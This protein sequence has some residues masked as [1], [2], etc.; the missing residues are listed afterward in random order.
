[1][2]GL[3]K[4]RHPAAERVEVLLQPD[5]RRQPR[6]RSTKLPEHDAERVSR[7]ARSRD[8]WRDFAA[9]PDHHPVRARMTRGAGKRI[10][11]GHRVHLRRRCPARHPAPRPPARS[12]SPRSSADGSVNDFTDASL[13][14][15]RKPDHALGRRGTRTSTPRCTSVFARCCHIEFHPD[16]LR[17]GPYIAASF[18]LNAALSATS[19]RSWTSSR[20]KPGWVDTCRFGCFA[21]A[22][23]AS[24]ILC[25]TPRPRRTRR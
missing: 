24:S 20:S 14:C 22:A 6:F 18:F 9:V 17:R 8:K 13:N 21:S 3:K 5:P 15:R 1:M 11:C 23:A 2:N 25:S 16:G 19:I 12:R 4:T 7:H 10:I